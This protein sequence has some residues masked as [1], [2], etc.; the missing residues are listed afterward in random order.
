ME[1]VT[2]GGRQ[3]QKY[4]GSEGQDVYIAMF[5]EDQDKLLGQYATEE[6]YDIVIDND[7][8]FYLPPECDMLTATSCEQEC[9]S[10]M[11]ALLSAQES[12]FDCSYEDLHSH[13]LCFI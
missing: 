7:A 8:D 2:I 13:L 10:C 1:L 3:W 12:S 11:E 9:I 4:K 5:L 6:S